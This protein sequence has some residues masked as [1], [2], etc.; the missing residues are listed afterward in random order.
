MANVIGENVKKYRRK[1]GYTPRRLADLAEIDLII[2]RGIE[3]G[4]VIPEPET[5]QK[6]A[7]YLNMTPQ[8]LGQK[9]LNHT[10]WTLKEM[11]EACDFLDIGFH[12][13]EKGD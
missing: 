4:D 8:N 3:S 1:C 10:E 11:V 12:V 5:M 13:G 6:L 7:D 9:L 2:Y